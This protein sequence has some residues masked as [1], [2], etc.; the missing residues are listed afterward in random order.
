MKTN[1]FLEKIHYPMSVID[2]LSTIRGK[3]FFKLDCS[4]A[5][6]QLKLSPATSKLLILVT[7]WGCFEPI[8]MPYGPSAAP[9]EFQA[10]ITTILAGI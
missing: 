7:P 5:F 4:N 8:T 2:D 10:A 9:L 3:C 6:M 1:Q